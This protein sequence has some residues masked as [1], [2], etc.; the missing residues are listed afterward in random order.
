MPVS[1]LTILRMWFATIFGRL[2]SNIAGGAKSVMRRLAATNLKS[3]ITP[4]TLAAA[5]IVSTTLCL[6]SITAVAVLAVKVSAR[7]GKPAAV[8]AASAARPWLSP[9]S[10]SIQRLPLRPD[11]VARIDVTLSYVNVGAEPARGV[12]VEMRSGTHQQ[13]LSTSGTLNAVFAGDNP[14][15]DSLIS[16]EKGGIVF[17]S[18]TVS[19]SYSQ[20]DIM[21]DEG[22]I[23]AKEGVLV[24]QACMKYQTSDGTIHTTKFCQYVE[25]EMD[26]PLD[27]RRM[28]ACADGNDAN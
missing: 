21:T 12:V 23:N 22:T 6:L 15:C 24:V 20:T 17:P 4:R 9:V 14:T 5:T 13:D 7:S 10:I 25:P 19:R 26:K 27:K 2:G 16:P 18:R 3:W 8:H 11:G 1:F 28:R